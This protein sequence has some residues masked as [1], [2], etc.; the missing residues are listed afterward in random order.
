MVNLGSGVYL[1]Q[2]IF[3][4][5]RSYLSN[6]KSEPDP[7]SVKI[8]HSPFP[9]GNNLSFNHEKFD[10]Y[11]LA[12]DFVGL[13]DGV[14]ENL[15]K[16]RKYLADQLLRSATSMPLNIAEGAGKLSKDSKRIFFQFHQH[17]QVNV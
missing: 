6:N 9:K 1:N 12:I 11:N 10:V 15:P 3:I 7:I 17:Q 4:R 2:Q 5:P 13:A 8:N 16:G 14:I